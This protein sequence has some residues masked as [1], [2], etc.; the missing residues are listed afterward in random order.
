M[1]MM[2]QSKAWM[3]EKGSNLSVWAEKHKHTI[4]KWNIWSLLAVIAVF[5][6]DPALAQSTTETM[7]WEGPLET[8]MNSLC[9]PV[10]QFAAVIAFVVT[11]LLVAFGELSGLFSVMMRV[12][13]GLSIA[14]FAVNFLSFFGVAGG[15]ACGR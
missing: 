1:S 4:L 11:G 14:L 15:F 12:A 10:A 3:A 6:I 13:F 8:V 9:G 5:T 7:P 2:D